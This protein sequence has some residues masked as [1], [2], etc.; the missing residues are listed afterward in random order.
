MLYTC[1]IFREQKKMCDEKGF[2]LCVKKADK[3]LLTGGKISLLEI[4]CLWYW[5]FQQVNLG[6]EK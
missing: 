6:I 5:A 2:V 1:E 4:H 3:N